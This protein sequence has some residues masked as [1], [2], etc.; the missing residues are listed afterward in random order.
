MEPSVD[1]VPREEFVVRSLLADFPSV[2]HQDAISA[3]HRGQTMRDHQSGATLHQ[4]EECLLH[5]AL[6]FRVKGR[7]RFIEDEDRRVLEKRAGDG[8]ALLLPARR[9][10]PRSPITVS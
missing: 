7:G 6:G 4:I 2:E 9:R 3:A 5:E 8:D 10:E 1:A